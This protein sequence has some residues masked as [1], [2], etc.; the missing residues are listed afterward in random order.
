MLLFF[1]KYII[2]PIAPIGQA[3]VRMQDKVVSGGYEECIELE[4]KAY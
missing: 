3:F 1:L 2:H 4:Q